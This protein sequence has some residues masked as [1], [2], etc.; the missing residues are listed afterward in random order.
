MHK[1]SILIRSFRSIFRVLLKWNRFNEIKENI[2]KKYNRWKKET[3]C[4]FSHTKKKKETQTHTHN[5]K[6]KKKKKK[7]IEMVPKS[8]EI[9][10]GYCQRRIWEQQIRFKFFIHIGIK[11]FRVKKTRFPYSVISRFTHLN[12]HQWALE[13]FIQSMAEYLNTTENQDKT[14]H[15][16]FIR[17]FFRPTQTLRTKC[18]FFFLIF[19]CNKYVFWAINVFF[20]HSR[21][22]QFFEYS[23]Y[24]FWK[25]YFQWIAPLNWKLEN[26][27]IGLKS[28]WKTKM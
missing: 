11:E 23:M 10:G 18:I 13:M 9:V 17:N 5:N 21:V 2:E 1:I 19:L 22:F 7:R 6:E 26:L 16:F 25:F 24:W 4:L 20:S 3:H 14:N 28:E 15:K 8:V 27:R 12:A